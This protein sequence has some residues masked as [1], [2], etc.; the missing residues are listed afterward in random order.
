[1]GFRFRKSINSGPFRI[2][3]SKS[4]IGASVGVPGARL[5]KTATGR[6]RKTLSIPGTG[7]SYV[8]ESGGKRKKRAPAST[9]A[10]QTRQPA[11]TGGLSNTLIGVTCLSFFFA[12]A[13][14]WVWVL[15]GVLLVIAII[16]TVKTHQN[17]E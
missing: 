8:T 11:A 10:G 14:P 1:M 15:F 4:G 13:Y 3:I 5:T 9:A 2:N 16:V 12:F 6:T 17:R 7:I